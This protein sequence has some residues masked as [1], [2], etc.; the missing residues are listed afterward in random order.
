MQKKQRGLIVVASVVITL[1]CVA[2]FLT[3][4]PLPETKAVATVT[5]DTALPIPNPNPVQQASNHASVAPAQPAPTVTEVAMK[6]NALF[7]AGAYANELNY[8]TYSR[9]LTKYDVD[10]LEPN[11][12]AKE[13]VPINDDGDQLV[14]SLAKYRFNSPEKIELV[15]RGPGIESSEVV[16]RPV[17]T[18]DSL[19]AARFTPK[20]G[21]WT[22]TIEGNDTFPLELELMVDSIVQGKRIPM[23]AHVK[24]SQPTATLIKVDQPRAFD[25]DMR[26]AMTFE[27]KKAGLYR[28]KANLFSS[29]GV[30][31]AHLVAR[32]KLSTGRQTMNIS[33]HVSVLK[34]QI[35]P[36][37]LKT[38]V[39]E[40]MS[41]SPGEPK[42]YGNS[43][44]KELKVD[45]FAVEALVDKPYE[46]SPA[47]LQRL[48]FLQKMAE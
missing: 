13:I 36:F 28:V 17:G 46:P 48:Q 4:A 31:V 25:S 33:A 45:D 3:E 42:L 1:V 43:D 16:A 21:Y 19:A 11:F 41:P 14:L 39:V 18:R 23:I 12:F 8:P 44:V 10:R 38:F 32:E 37:T 26:F 15:L 5:N 22:A 9:P 34:D 35:A 47:E 6:S 30:P 29:S 27:V 40:L 7:I 20:Q 2:W 24:Y